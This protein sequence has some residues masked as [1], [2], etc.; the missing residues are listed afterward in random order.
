MTNEQTDG[1]SKISQARKVGVYAKP[2]VTGLARHRQLLLTI[3][4]ALVLMVIMWLVYRFIF[5]A[6]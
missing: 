6:D 1:P 3:L 2:E 4:I 5:K